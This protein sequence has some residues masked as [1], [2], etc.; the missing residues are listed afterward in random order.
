MGYGWK[1]LKAAVEQVILFPSEWSF[2][3][4]FTE[5][6]QKGAPYEIVRKS[7]NNDGTITVV[8]RKQYN[9]NEFLGSADELLS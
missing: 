5:L 1:I 6:V 3:A 7:V 8:V 9:Q 2:R 4:Y